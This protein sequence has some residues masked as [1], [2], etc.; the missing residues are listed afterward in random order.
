MMCSRFD[1]LS[2]E[3]PKRLRCRGADAHDIK[4][5]ITAIPCAFVS[6]QAQSGLATK[7]VRPRDS[8]SSISRACLEEKNFR[9]EISRAC[10]ETC[11]GVSQNAKRILNIF[12]N[13]SI[14]LLKIFSRVH[15]FHPIQQTK[16]AQKTRQC[17]MQK[18]IPPSAAID[19]SI[20]CQCG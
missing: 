5:L 19:T 16:R 12:Q 4:F 1:T 6:T 20:A 15:P 3:V 17:F 10:L 13:F 14:Q 2:T 8:V 7:E 11:S 9:A 18:I